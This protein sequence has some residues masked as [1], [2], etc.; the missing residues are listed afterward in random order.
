[1][2][3]AACDGCSDLSTSAALILGAG[4]SAAAGLPLAAD[5][6]AGPLYATS[7]AAVERASRVEDDGFGWPQRD[8][9]KWPHF[10][11]VDVLVR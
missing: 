2:T 3:A 6:I 10:V 11:L 8:G 7:Q 5:L 9:L 1:V 4:W